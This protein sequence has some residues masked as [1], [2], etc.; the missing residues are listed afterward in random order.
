MIRTFVLLYLF[1]GFT[2]PARAQDDFHES[3]EPGQGDVVE[4]AAPAPARTAERA[5]LRALLKAYKDATKSKDGAQIA[6]ALETLTTLDN[7]DVLKPAKAAF[8]YKPS[9]VDRDWAA[10]EAMATGFED[11]EIEIERLLNQRRAQIEIAATR[12]LAYQPIKKAGPILV[13]AFDDGDLRTHRPLAAKAILEVF[14]RFEYVEATEGVVRELN[15][16]RSPEMARSCINFLVNIDTKNEKAFLTLCDLLLGPAPAN[17]D[18][19]TNPPAAYWE[20]RWRTW[21]P[22]RRDVQAALRKL[23]GRDWKADAGDTPGDADAAR[24]WVKDNAKKL[25]LK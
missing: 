22:L 8:T 11:D 4:A 2:T 13:R 5:E 1:A 6:A 15:E 7:P 12:V 25:G 21:T 18:D 19:P 24:R 3:D 9:R 14:A 17:V 10:A 16:L 20:A 23:T